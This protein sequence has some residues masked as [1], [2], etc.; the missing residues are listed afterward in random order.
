MKRVLLLAT[1]CLIAPAARADRAR[2]LFLQ[3]PDDVGLAAAYYPASGD[4]TLSPAAVFLHA[5]G[6]SRDEWGSLPLLL[7]HN[8]IA[9][10]NFDFR[11]HGESRRRLTADGPQLVDHQTFTALDFQKLLLDINTVVDWLEDQPGIDKR[12]IVLIGSSLGANLAVRYAIEND[13]LAGLILFSPGLAYKD[14]RIDDVFPQMRRLPLRVV[15][16]VRDTFAY[17]SSRR[18]LDARRQNG[19]ARDFKELIA[20]SGQQHGTEQLRV[21]KE[22]PVVLIRWLR[23]LFFTEGVEET[24]PSLPPPTVTT[25]APAA[26][27]SRRPNRP[28]P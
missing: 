10:L 25:N 15:V 7:Q 27:P 6:G 20:C 18:L 17:E 1:A 12:R 4:N 22:L 9:V 14:V 23:Q 11:G 16:S 3:T 8:G 5:L 19:R 28:L 13:D 2:T 21:V 24:A 26:K